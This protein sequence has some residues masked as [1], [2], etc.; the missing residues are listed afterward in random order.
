MN[1][2]PECHPADALSREDKNRIYFSRVVELAIVSGL[3]IPDPD[4]EVGHFAFSRHYY[5]GKE[6]D[7]KLRF[8]L[9]RFEA[10]HPEI[11]RER[12]D[13]RNESFLGAVED[14]LAAEDRDKIQELILMGASHAIWPTGTSF[15]LTYP[16]DLSGKGWPVRF[17]DNLTEFMKRRVLEI[18]RKAGKLRNP[19][20]FANP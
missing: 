1:S 4:T 17:R 12:R 3:L 5:Q 13:V 11:A 7:R 19:E 6:L 9:I 2:N 8:A 10:H 15:V 14:F 18:L 16:W 20:L